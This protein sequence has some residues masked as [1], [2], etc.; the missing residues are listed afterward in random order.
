MFKKSACFAFI[1]KTEYIAYSNQRIMYK[2]KESFIIRTIIRG[3]DLCSFLHKNGTM[4]F[5]LKAWSIK[6]T[7]TQEV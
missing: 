5:G 1:E 7:K 4:S 6:E 2:H 3:K